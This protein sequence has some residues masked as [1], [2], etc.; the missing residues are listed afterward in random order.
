MLFLKHKFCEEVM[1]IHIYVCLCSYVY[2]MA[3]INMFGIFTQFHF[4]SPFLVT[5]NL[6]K[7][8]DFVSVVRSMRGINNFIKCNRAT[9][10]DNAESTPPLMY[11]QVHTLPI[12]CWFL[13]FYASFYMLI[14][15]IDN[16]FDFVN[17]HLAAT[18]DFN[19]IHDK[20]SLQHNK[21]I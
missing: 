10:D 21:Y 12:V 17:S 2:E 19:K 14:I 4:H 7:S 20:I 5:T 16:E 15:V 8:C 3:S 13:C 6:C 9:G 11:V 1:R 18:V